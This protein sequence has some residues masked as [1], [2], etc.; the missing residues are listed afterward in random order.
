[1][2]LGFATVNSLRNIDLRIFFILLHA[3]VGIALLSNVSF[4]PSWRTV[5]PL[6]FLA[7]GLGP[8]NA[9]LAGFWAWFYGL[10][11]SPNYATSIAPT[12]CSGSSCASYFLPGAIY[13][14][15]PSP[16][17]FTDHQEAT[18]F[19]I[20]NS[21]GYQLEFYPFASTDNL[22]DAICS[23]YGTNGVNDSS[24]IMLCM[25][26]SSNDLL[27][28]YPIAMCINIRLSV[29]SCQYQLPQRQELAR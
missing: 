29:M 3:G 21:L 2:S 17:T 14:A 28:G 20:N 16:D 18:A 27:F 13:V 15:D 12:H 8:I 1:L 26:Q 9:S 5:E 19:V 25:K 24:A 11:V 23:T 10:L 4:V 22:T 6:S 7:S